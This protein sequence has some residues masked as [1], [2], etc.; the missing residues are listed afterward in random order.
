ME[1]KHPN[2]A[3][4]AHTMPTVSTSVLQADELFPV[5]A[6]FTVAG[7]QEQAQKPEGVQGPGGGGS[8]WAQK[9]HFPP[10]LALGMSSG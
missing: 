6:G 4:F 1:S 3:G 2:H 9:V 5:C 10:K 7:A 8:I